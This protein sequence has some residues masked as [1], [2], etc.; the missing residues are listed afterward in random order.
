MSQGSLGTYD[1]MGSLCLDVLSDCDAFENR[2]L[3]C[4]LASCL[5]VVPC[6]YIYEQ[7]SDGECH[8]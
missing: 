3:S 7:F 8:L 2:M 4:D 5:G 6:C 1:L